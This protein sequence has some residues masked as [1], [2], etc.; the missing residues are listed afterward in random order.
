MLQVYGSSPNVNV[1]WC[2]LCLALRVY[3]RWRLCGACTGR[4]TTAHDR[5]VGRESHR[6]CTDE[7]R[8][9]VG[10][11]QHPKNPARSTNRPATAPQL[12]ATAPVPRIP[13]AATRGLGARGA[14]PGGRHGGREPRSAGPC[15]GVRPSARGPR[16]PAPHRAAPRGPRPREGRRR[17]GW[18]AEPRPARP[19]AAAARE[20]SRGRRAAQAGP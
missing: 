12:T 3:A 6:E 4:R 14:G 9:V 7:L 15:T 8:S 18:S 16:P 17:P 11:L 1:G 5:C 2:A 10:V 20:P 13:I 19:P